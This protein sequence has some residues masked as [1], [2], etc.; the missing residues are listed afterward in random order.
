MHSYQDSYNLQQRQIFTANLR[1]LRQSKE[2]AYK[3]GGKVLYKQANY[4]LEKEIRLAKR[5]YSGKLRKK[6][7]S[8]DSASVWIGMKDI[9]NYKTPTPSHVENQQ[10]AH[11]LNKFY[12]RFKKKNKKKTFHTTP[13]PHTCTADN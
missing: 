8:S 3:K 12:C 1:Q 9:T 5:N 4:T 2:D 6:L 13:P 11:D 7:P 10:L